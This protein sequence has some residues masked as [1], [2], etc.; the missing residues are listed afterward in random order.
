M[1]LRFKTVIGKIANEAIKNF[2]GYLYFFDSHFT[3]LAILGMTIIGAAVYFTFG[4]LWRYK[5][6]DWWRW[7]ARALFKTVR[8]F[9]WLLI[10][11]GVLK[12]LK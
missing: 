12:V 2:T 4:Y 11:K 5:K 3:Y 8:L 7:K 1:K 10:I 9:V 6:Y